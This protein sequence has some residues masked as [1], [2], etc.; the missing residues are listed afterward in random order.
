M[1]RFSVPSPHSWLFRL[2]QQ[3]LLFAR[4]LF[5]LFSKKRTAILAVQISLEVRSFV[6]KCKTQLGFANQ[7]QGRWWLSS[8]GLL[9]KVCLCASATV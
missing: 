1:E 2:L 6:C 7:S 4:L 9:A 3:I 8:F 5:V